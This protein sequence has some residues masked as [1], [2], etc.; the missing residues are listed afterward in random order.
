MTLIKLGPVLIVV[1]VIVIAVSLLADFLG[2]GTH[3]SAIG[4]I[5]LLGAAVGLVI[6][7]VGIILIFRKRKAL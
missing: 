5:Q 7:I 3:P 2:I 6:T 4:P 1:G